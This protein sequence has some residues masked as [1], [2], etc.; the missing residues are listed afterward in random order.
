[1]FSWI[2]N[3]KSCWNNFDFLLISKLRTERKKGILK[4]VEVFKQ[5]LKP[6]FIRLA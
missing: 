6:K 2:G 5:M 1:M 4:H 3:L